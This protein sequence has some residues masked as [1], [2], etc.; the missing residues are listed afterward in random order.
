MNPNRSNKTRTHHFEPDRIRILD[1]SRSARVPIHVAFAATFKE[2][3]YR[4]VRE[5]RIATGMTQGAVASALGIP[6]RSYQHFEHRSP[7]PA[8]LIVPFA[9]LVGV[10]VRELLIGRNWSGTNTSNEMDGA[11][12]G[13]RAPFIEAE[14]ADA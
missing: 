8:H 9:D 2:A 12:K 3:F 13:R 10:D 6:L 14:I 1:A 4:R 7:L 5:L 11:P